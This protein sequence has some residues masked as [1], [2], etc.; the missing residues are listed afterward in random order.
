MARIPCILI[1][2]ALVLVCIIASIYDV[3]VESLYWTL[4]TVYLPCSLACLVSAVAWWKQSRFLM[5]VG[6]ISLSAIDIGSLI[7]VLGQFRPWSPVTTGLCFLLV[8]TIPLTAL[9]GVGWN[10]LR[11]EFEAVTNPP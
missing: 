3:T 10:S 6:T 9:Q 4:Y 2:S 5:L 7:F 1:A 11:H 8:V